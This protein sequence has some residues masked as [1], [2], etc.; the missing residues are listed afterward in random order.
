MAIRLRPR[1]C[2][3]I[4]AVLVLVLPNVTAQPA[5]S[6]EDPSYLLTVRP[7]WTGPSRIRVVKAPQPSAEIV[8]TADG[9]EYLL[10]VPLM[11][12]GPDVIR[13]EVQN[14]PSYV[15]Q[16]V[17]SG[18]YMHNNFVCRVE[19][20]PWMPQGARRL[21]ADETTQ[22]L[23]SAGSRGPLP[24]QRLASSGTPEQSSWGQ[25]AQPPGGRFDFGQ[26]SGTA[27]Q[28]ASRNRT[29]V[30]P[31]RLDSIHA[32][33]PPS[34]DV[35]VESTDFAAAHSG[36]LGKNYALLFATDDYKP[37][38][39]PLTN[40]I[41]DASAI[42]QELK[43]RYGFEVDP[44]Y[45]Q[46]KEQ[47]TRTIL[48][49]QQKKY[50]PNDQLLIF[51]AG[52]GDYDPTRKK[53]FLV[54]KDSQPDDILRSSFIS[55][56]DLSSDI[57]SIPCKHILV[58]LDTCYSGAF[59][60]FLAKFFPDTRD[61]GDGLSYRQMSFDEL[62]QTYGHLPTRLLLASAG[63]MAVSDGIPGNHS[64]FASKFLELLRETAKQ[65]GYLTFGDLAA[66]M[67]KVPPGPHIKNLPG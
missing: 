19:G 20:G 47:I 15:R 53:G 36:K 1:L 57:I 17:R 2:A 14:Q 45:N 39:K 48:K 27:A 6:Y 50:S 30:P 56:P 10:L 54:T 65:G 8:T 52:H 58:V 7:G 43:S 40:P 16:Y 42:A 23:G 46:G 12:S 13:V 60:E 49:Y 55:F 21:S 32:I 33:R 11:W 29:K 67:K 64:P 24:T 51:F 34:R 63:K 22:L 18:R 35:R 31:R 38:F 62:Y 61:A 5:H 44:Q 59:D 9:S 3:L 25:L 28:A 26:P 41:L 66:P 4:A 37:G